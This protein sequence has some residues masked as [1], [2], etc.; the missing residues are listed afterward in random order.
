MQKITTISSHVI[1]LLLDNVD[2][3]QIIPARFLKTTK[4]DGLGEHLFTDWRYHQDGTPNLEFIFNQPDV[5]G[6]KILLAGTNFGCG[7]SREHAP[8][9]LL[10]WGIQAVIA[11]SFAD[12]FRSNALKNGLLPVELDAQEHSE[13]AR[14]V[15]HDPTFHSIIDLPTQTISL[16]SDQTASFPINPFARHC[17]MEGIDQLNYILSFSEKILAYEAA[18]E[19]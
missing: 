12:I 3:D 13:I 15:L 16:S 7:S 11:R 14:T 9:A 6:A 1:P 2:T 4:K 5:A 18:H 17:L 10:D 8:W 19:Q